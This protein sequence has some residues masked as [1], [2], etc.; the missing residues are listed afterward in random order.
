[1]KIDGVSLKDRR[2]RIN[3]A[4]DF[5]EDHIGDKYIPVIESG[6]AL[7]KKFTSLEN[8]AK[9]NNNKSNKKKRTIDPYQA[10]Y[11]TP[12]EIEEWENS[13]DY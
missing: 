9:R 8:A 11:M 1:M 12:E 10:Q 7:R 3:E 2:S 13:E 5:Y 4:L 6:A